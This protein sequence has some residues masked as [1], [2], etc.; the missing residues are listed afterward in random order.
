MMKLIANNVEGSGSGLTSGHIICL[1]IL[2]NTK[3]DVSEWNRYRGRELKWAPLECN[4]EALPL[5]F[6][7]SAEFGYVV[8]FEVFTAVTMKKAVFWDVASCSSCVNRRFGATRSRWFLVR[9]FFYL[10]DGGDTFL[11]NVGLYKNYT[12][13]HPRWRHSLWFS[14]L[15]MV[16]QEGR[17]VFVL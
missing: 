1:K 5:Q 7:F 15:S 8:R 17:N 13:Q 6:S 9:E 16:Y 3:K 10:E 11:R 4:P 2:R 12:A 14:C